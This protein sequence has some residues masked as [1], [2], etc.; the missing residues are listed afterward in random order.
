MLIYDAGPI[1]TPTRVVVKQ[2][3]SPGP[4]YKVN[5]RPTPYN[6]GNTSAHAKGGLSVI[7]ESEDAGFVNVDV[8]GK[9]TGKLPGQL[10]K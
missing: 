9:T 1:A 5:K 10:S 2:E 6:R 7:K 8:K 3:P 4:S